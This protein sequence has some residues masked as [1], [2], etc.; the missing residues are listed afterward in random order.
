M[1]PA[2]IPAAI[3]DA[4]MRIVQGTADAD[5]QAAKEWAKKEYPGGPGWVP[6]G[7]ARTYGAEGFL[8]GVAYGRAQDRGS[9]MQL[10]EQWSADAEDSAEGQGEP[11]FG[12]LMR[13]AKVMRNFAAAIRAST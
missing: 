8:A 7:P 11:E 6:V 9:W 5:R 13:V 10:A 1:T 3:Y 2:P 12:Q 4:A